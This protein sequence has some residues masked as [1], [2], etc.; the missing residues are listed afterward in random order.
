MKRH[1]VCAGLSIAFVAAAAANTIIDTY[2]DWDG[3]VTNGWLKI[4]QT[5]TVP[6]DNVLDNWKF[7]LNPP[8]GQNTIL[9][10]IYE[11]DNS[12]GPIGPV[13][14][15]SI[16]AWPAAGGDVLVDN[17]NLPLTT[18]NLYGAIVD[19]QGYAGQSVHFQVNQFS[20]TGGDASWFDGATWN[21]LNSGWNTKFRAEFTPEPATLLTLSVA[22][23]ALLR[24]RRM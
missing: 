14:Y 22:A 6:A 13:L 15:S 16:E 7:A 24:R 1:L 11:W 19:L 18:G 3:N 20:Y 4:A 9:F 23:L 5:V 8:G 17:I 21:F 2:P 10:E 12:V